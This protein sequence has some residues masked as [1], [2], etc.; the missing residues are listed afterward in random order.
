MFA[1]R[2]EN[3][4]RRLQLDGNRLRRVDQLSRSQVGVDRG[5][6]Q[7]LDVEHD[8]R[9]GG[10][11]K[12]DD[13]I[14]DTERALVAEHLGVQVRRAAGAEQDRQGTKTALAGLLDEVRIQ[15][16][17]LLPGARAKRIDHQPVEARP[18]R[19]KSI[20]CVGREAM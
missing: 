6:A 3:R 11:G 2:H 12:G 18:L 4:R 16:L 1:Q 20:R 10:G 15:R 8:G 5:A 13:R 17:D 7:R 19:T 14:A 9:G